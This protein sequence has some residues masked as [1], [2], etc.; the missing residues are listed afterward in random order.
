MRDLDWKIL[1]VLNEKE[2]ITQTAQALFLT[3]SALTKRLRAIEN[4]WKVEIVIRTSKGVIFTDDG[5]YLAG[6]AAVM[7]DFLGEIAAHY[8]KLNGS[9]ELLRIGVPNSFARLHMPKLMKGYMKEFDELQFKTVSHSSDMIVKELIDETVDVGIVCGDY[10]FL[11]EKVCLF[12][13]ALFMVAPKGFYL[14]DVEQLP[15]IESYLNP[16]VKS[17]VD[18]WWKR[19]F[20]ARPREVHSVPYPEIAIE[21]V[22]NGLGHC[23]VFGDTWKFDR[24][25]AEVILICGEDGKRISRNVWMM[26]TDHCFKSQSIMDFVTYVE[27]YY[28]VN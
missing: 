27:K 15:F 21:M 10:N 7:L 24:S 9:K 22:E 26:L 25:K 5:R 13:E 8:A 23:F 28:Q 17:T 12:D 6:K 2:S 1:K 11:G 3:Q 4:E 18:Q 14:E 20:S 16:L 19:R